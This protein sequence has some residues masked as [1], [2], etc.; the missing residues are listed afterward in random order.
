MAHTPD[1]E[2]LHPPGGASVLPDQNAD[3]CRPLLGYALHGKPASM[4]VTVERGTRHGY[5]SN[6]MW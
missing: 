4:N 6:F 5:G 3:H 1:R 2:R